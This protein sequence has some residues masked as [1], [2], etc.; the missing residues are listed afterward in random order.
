[1][2]KNSSDIVL[3]AVIFTYNHEKYIEKCIDSILQQ[4]TNFG[5][6]IIVADDCSTDH[7]VK[8]VEEKYGDK[9][10]IRTKKS[11]VGFCRNIY[12]TFKNIEGKYIFLWNGDDYLATEKVFQS[13]VAF[14]ENHSEYFGVAGLTLL[15]NEMNG[16]KNLMKVDYEEYSL[17]SFLRGEPQ[18]FYFQT[19]RNTFVDDE[20]EYL[21]QASRNN[22][23]VQMQYYHLIKGKCAIIPEESYVYCYRK[24]EENYNYCS[25]HS[26]IEMLAD[27]ANGF[28]A[29]EKV[30][31]RQHNFDI[32]KLRRYEGYIDRI[33][34][35][36]DICQILEI[37]KVLKWSDIG[38]FI[39]L[40][41]LI[42]CNHHKMPEFLINEKRLIRKGKGTK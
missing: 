29:I 30:D 11:N 33:L 8:V 23:E 32:A 17:M 6:E 39:W 7:T 18:R 9:V 35:T 4:Q 37:K 27:Y 10:K 21:Y 24:N 13:Q 3:S 15:V 25:K 31:K 16:N 20:V 42:K 14:L 12:D 40:K 26:N 36:K 41:L 28:Y 1:M 34:E 5:Y 2:K 38:K 22:E 19:F